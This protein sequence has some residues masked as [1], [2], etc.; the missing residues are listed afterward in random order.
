M[1]LTGIILLLLTGVGWAAVGAVIGN[2]ARK[3]LSMAEIQACSALVQIAVAAAVLYRLPD[4]PCG[5]EVRLPALAAIWGGGFLNFFLWLLMRC[6]MKNGPNGIAWA[7]IQSAL[8]VPFLT[9]MLC[10]GEQ[11]APLRIIGLAMI[12][13]ALAFFAF[14]RD[15]TTRGNRKIWLLA[16]AGG[17]LLAGMNQT[18]VNLPS[19]FHAADAVS[20]VSRTLGFQAG[21]LCAFLITLP[22][23][24]SAA[25]AGFSRRIVRSVAILAAVNLTAGFFLQ[26]RGLNALAKAGYG[27]V[28]FPI[29]VSS[30][31]VFFTLYSLFFLKE[32]LSRMQWFGLCLCVGG[33]ALM[34]LRLAPAA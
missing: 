14:S 2:S 12:I 33:I 8:I 22:F 17:L 23:R 6:A 9:G 25:K 4:S 20:G 29:L 16:T 18:L 7:V 1:L 5:W 15:N 26:Y 24:R 11:P 31:L 34:S 32:R 30:C 10:F 21:T 3:N 13:G 28:S 19:Y 27:A